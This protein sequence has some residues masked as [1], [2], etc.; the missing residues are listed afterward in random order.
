MQSVPL[1]Q[2]IKDGGIIPSDVICAVDKYR[3]PKKVFENNIRVSRIWCG[4]D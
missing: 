2:L 1:A 3:S 4:D